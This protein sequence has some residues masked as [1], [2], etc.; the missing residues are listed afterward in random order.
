MACWCGYDIFF[1]MK[2]GLLRT[3]AST[4]KMGISFNTWRN[5]F[6]DGVHKLDLNLIL[7]GI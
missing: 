6:W 1:N 3:G 5:E 4:I 7:L 2:M